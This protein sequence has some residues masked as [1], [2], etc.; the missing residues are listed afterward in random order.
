MSI[1]SDSAV[2]CPACH[3]EWQD[4][5]GVAHTCKL[6]TEL[7]AH[8]RDILHYVQPPEYTRDITEQEVFFDLLENSRRLIVKARTFQNEL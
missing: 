2:A 5:P 8:L 7:A 6:A 3:R 4:H 1:L